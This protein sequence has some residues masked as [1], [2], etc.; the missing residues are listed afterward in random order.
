[1]KVV[2]AAVNAKFIHSNLAVRYLKAF[3]EDIDYD[4]SILEFSINDKRERV[5]EALVSEKPDILAFSCYI[6][7]IEYIKYLAKHFSLINPKCIILYGGPEVSFDAEAFLRSNVGDL[8]IQGEGEETFRELI[9]FAN[10]NWEKDVE[11]ILKKI[12]DMTI[13]GLFTKIGENIYCE[14]NREL[15]NINNTKFPYSDISELSNKI[16]YYEASRGCPFNCKYCLS[17]TSHGVRFLDME[18]I[19]QEL[20]YFIEGKVKLVKFVDRTFNCNINFAMDIW[21]FLINQKSDTKFHFEISADLLKEE[22]LKLLSRAPKDLFQ[23]EVGVQTTNSEVLKNI[24]RYVNFN[25]IKEKVCELEEVNNIKQHL[26]LIAGLPGEDFESFKNSFNDVY[27]I[28]PEEIQLGFLKLL[29]GSKMREE[30]AEWGMVYSPE[31]P[32]EILKSSAISYKELIDLK[33]V[34]EVLDKYYNSNKFQN[35]LNYFIPKFENP[36]QFYYELGQFFH[37]KGYLSRNISSADYYK[38]FI[39]FFEKVFDED[40]LVLKEII[41]YDYLKYNK[42]KWLPSFLNR[43]INKDLERCIKN[44]IRDG[45]IEVSEKFHVEKFFLDIKKFLEL[46]KEEKGEYYLLFDE[47]ENE[48]FELHYKEG[49]ALIWQ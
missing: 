8:V 43:E 32:Y 3:T 23:F 11:N 46:G 35:I 12:R 21:G 27:S 41:K 5:L 10:K 40:T 18:R 17:S 24:N 16:V 39:D 37:K 29:K 26:D 25:D 33:R 6:W 47:E 19:K 9:I 22:E 4:C 45:K 42:K 2:L 13:K 48:T 34:E 7:N 30:A 49:E 38:I 28:R 36:F 14:G 31:P 44:S 20:K 15:M 1:M